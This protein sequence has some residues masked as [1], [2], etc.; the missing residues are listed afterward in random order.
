MTSLNMDKLYCVYILTNSYN[1]VL[2]TGIT[3]DLKARVYQHREKLLPGFTSRYNVFKLVYYEAG[4]D[5]SG[6]IAR[7]KQIKAGS[8]QKKVD[9]INLTN[10]EWQDLYDR[11]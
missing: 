3:S 10:P 7:E 2:Y 11:L 4:D 1:T 5:A 6:A 9:L 8:R